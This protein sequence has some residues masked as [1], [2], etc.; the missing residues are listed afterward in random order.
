MLFV[1]CFYLSDAQHPPVYSH[2]CHETRPHHKK[3][4]CI[5][6]KYI[7][8]LSLSITILLSASS[9]FAQTPVDSLPQPDSLTAARVV[10]FREQIKP[11]PGGYAVRVADLPISKEAKALD[12]LKYLPSLNVNNHSVKMDG[13]SSI[14]VYIDGRPMRMSGQA[15]ADYLSA[16]PAGEIDRIEVQTLP[17]AEHSAAG[18]VG[19][20]RLTRQKDPTVGIRGNLSG[21]LGLNSY[22]SEMGSAFLEYNGKKAFISGSFSADD[23][24]NLRLTRYSADYPTGTMDVNNPMKWHTQSLSG[25]LSAGWHITERDLLIA[26]VRIPASRSRVSDLENTTRWIPAE[27]ASEPASTLYADGATTSQTLTQDYSLYYRHDFP[28]GATWSA[29]AAWLTRGVDRDRAFRSR[30]ETGGIIIPEADYESIGSFRHDVF[31]AKTDMVIPKGRWRITTGA[32]FSS[33]RSVAENSFSADVVPTSHFDYAEQVAAVYASADAS[34]GKWMLYG[35]LRGEYTWT[36]ATV[37]NHYGDL[38]PTVSVTRRFGKAWSATLQHTSRISRP[39]F[40]ALN[41][42]RWYL[43]PYSY[44]QG[45]P[46]LEPSRL[47]IT[48]ISLME[49]R[50]FKTDISWAHQKGQVGSLVLLDADQPLLQVEQYGNFLD[51]DRLAWS[52]YYLFQGGERYVAIARGNLDYEWDRSDRPEFPSTHGFGAFLRLTQN[53][54]LGKS[55]SITCDISD[56]LPGFYNY[57]RRNNSFQMD[58]SVEYYHSKSGLRVTLEATDIF[59][60]ADSPYTYTS[61]GVTLHY[62]NYLDTR[63]LLL[64][65]SWRFGNWKKRTPQAVRSNQEENG[66][67]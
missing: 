51:V 23:L 64:T 54:Q 56:N 65:V 16:L 59:K 34:L 12:V 41:P 45:D 20:I 24:R 9:L 61:D 53:V 25:S 52:I 38:F 37:N 4:F 30:T 40:S 57:R 11:V 33:V 36:Q 19:V 47:Y 42:F 1:R 3:Y 39:S 44:S 27:G 46:Y 50:N 43:T 29:S 17:T 60:T 18:N 58:L 26:D 15:L 31:T 6:K 10:A 5:L 8:L 62:N 67:L 35:G 7:P 13:R 55:F 63:S 2:L 48:E 49:G 32:K 22:L 66:R 28:S 14:K 21:S